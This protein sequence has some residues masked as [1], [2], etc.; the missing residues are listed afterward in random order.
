MIDH[1]SCDASFVNIQIAVRYPG[2][3][4]TLVTRSAVL[5]PTMP[6][7]AQQVRDR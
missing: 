2:K 7:A 3:P 4:V 6:T 1:S 5:L